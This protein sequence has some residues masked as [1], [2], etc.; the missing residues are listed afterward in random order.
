[1]AERLCVAIVWL[2]VKFKQKTYLH[3]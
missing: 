2:M 1:V 3:D